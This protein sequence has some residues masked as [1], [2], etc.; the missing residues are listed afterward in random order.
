LGDI[1]NNTGAAQEVMAITGKFFDDQGQVIA[2]EGSGYGYAAVMVIPAGNRVPFKL[3][4]DI[5]GM[6]TADL[7]V[8]AQP[9]PSTPRQD[10]KFLDTYDRNEEFGYCLGGMLQ[11][12]GQPLQ[13]SVMI[14]A[15]LYDAQDNVINF[16][17]DYHIFPYDLSSGQAPFEVCVDTFNQAVARHEL[18][19]WGQ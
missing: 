11:N 3:L 8:E 15:V 19:S 6:T 12:P 13:E 2:G 1:I 4:V 7:I 16:S 18:Q 17:N 5:Q 10:F 14:V 9:G